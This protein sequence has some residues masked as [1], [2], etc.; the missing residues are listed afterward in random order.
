MQNW[1]ARIKAARQVRR[2]TAI[3]CNQRLPT[4]MAGATNVSSE[5]REPSIAD[6]GRFRLLVRIQRASKRCNKPFDVERPITAGMFAE[7]TRFRLGRELRPCSWPVRGRRLT[8]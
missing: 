6:L 8:R 5:A 3:L 7:A 4:Q 1:R 2:M